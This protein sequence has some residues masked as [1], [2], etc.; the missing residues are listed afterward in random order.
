MDCETVRVREVRVMQVASA[1]LRKGQLKMRALRDAIGRFDF[2]CAHASGSVAPGPT[3]EMEHID[4]VVNAL[5]EA[6]VAIR[7]LD[8][9]VFNASDPA[10][11]STLRQGSASGTTVRGLTAPRNNAVHDS[12][13][14]DPDIARAIGPL[15]GDRF[16]IFPRWK[17]RM[18]LPKQMFQHAMGKQKGQDHAALIASY[19]SAVA[20][21]VVLDTLMDA[22]AFFD[23][24]DPRLA[25]RDSEG[26]L[27]GFPLA[28]LPVAGDYRRLHPD[29]PNHETVDR[30]IRQ[31][32][33]DE[34]PAGRERE[35]T[36]RLNSPTGIVY[37]GYTD[38]RAGYRQ[39]FT[40]PAAQVRRDIEMGFPYYATADGVRSE[41]TIDG[42]E[43]RVRCETLD[44][45]SLQDW[46][47][48][49]DEPWRGWWDLCSSDGGYYRSQRRAT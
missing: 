49:D 22:F 42:A 23:G 33:S 14:I 9:E 29:W 43:L 31:L 47:D 5:D 3:L 40:E 7:T 10:G 28:P 48:R 35:I 24:C 6:L 21:R 16:I 45:L 32:A 27:R 41:V 44:R 25:D 13:V 34:V 30:N 39:A 11:Y 8:L 38:V 37:C 2:A 4:P 12:D 17:N 26:K 20:G 18:S 36:G 46:T 19:D 1:R 15:E